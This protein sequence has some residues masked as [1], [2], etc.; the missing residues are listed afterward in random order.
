MEAL[1]Q[2]YSDPEPLNGATD[3]E[4]LRALYRDARALQHELLSVP[5]GMHVRAFDGRVHKAA[6]YWF[7]DELA[8]GAVSELYAEF[9]ALVQELVPP[10]L[11]AQKAKAAERAERVDRQAQ[12]KAAFPFI[13][14]A[15]W[16]TWAPHLCSC[17]SLDE[18]KDWVVK[19]MD[20]TAQLEA[21]FPDLSPAQWEAW[22][23]NLANYHAGRS[24]LAGAKRVVTQ[25][26]N[27]EAK[28]S[29]V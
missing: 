9:Q 14:E 19:A 3:A 8:D 20:R 13:S 25:A 17:R 23:P 18:A 27:R 11:T 2:R 12:L 10:L 16:K 29:K 28:R 5:G 26:K 1:L 15:Q 4:R 6:F 24:T 7:E 21:A 22:A